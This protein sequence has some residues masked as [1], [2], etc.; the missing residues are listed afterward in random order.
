MIINLFLL[1]IFNIFIYI[2]IKLVIKHQGKSIKY[3]LVHNTTTK[4]DLF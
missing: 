2:T 4:Y 1:N 3:F